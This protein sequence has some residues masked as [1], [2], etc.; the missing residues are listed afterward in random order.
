METLKRNKAIFAGTSNTIGLGLELEF[1]K[2]FQDDNYLLN[3][4]KQIPPIETTD[5]N[6]D[7][8]TNEDLENQRKYRWPKL[9]CDYFSLT[10]I[11][12]NDPTGEYPLDILRDSRQAVDLVFKLHDERNDENVKKL[13]NETKYIF[14]EF[15]YIRWW[16]EDLHGKDTNF[17]WPSTPAE[18]D[19][20]LK[21]K[22][23]DNEKKLK[24]IDWL[25]ELNPVD[26]WNRTSSKITEMKKEF[27]DIKFIL[28]TWGVNPELYNLESSKPLIEDFLEIMDTDN[29][30]YKYDISHFLE[31]HK[32]RIFDN[33]K[34]YNS[35]YK[36]KWL[37]E[38]YHANSKGQQIIANRIIKK[39][40]NETRGLYTI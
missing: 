40:Q 17:I 14:L 27:S 32:L 29:K 28:L 31:T 18:I 8:Y 9:V 38:D 37:Y 12:A 23:I 4:C 2:R 3:I 10:E 36:N 20:F 13:L 22:N 19:L 1:S 15:G 6:Y 30:Q 16:E 11:N 33:V 5:T 26:L 21:D 25:N 7:R 39:L 35:K 24:A 34:A